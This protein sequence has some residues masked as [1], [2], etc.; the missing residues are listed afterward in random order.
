M[1]YR[2]VE[3]F[4]N[5]VPDN[6][7]LHRTYG[8]LPF[9]KETFEVKK[10]SEILEQNFDEANKRFHGKRLVVHGTI[11]N[12]GKDIHD[13][14]SFELSDE[15]GGYCYVLCC[16][17]TEAE[18]G[19]YEIGDEVIV[20][21]NY[22]TVHEQF[23]ICLKNCYV[24]GAKPTRISRLGLG[25][26]GMNMSNK[27]SSIETIHYAL[28]HGINLLNTGEFYGGGESE[29]VL[30]EALKDVPREKYFLSLKF[31]VLPQPGGGIYGLDVNPFNV[32]GHLA[33]SLHRLGL[34]YVDL[35][36]PARMDET[37]PV[38]DLME[39]MNEVVEEGY[40]RNIGL[41]QLSP[42]NLERAV[43]VAKIKTIELDY[44]LA[45]RSIE[46]NG[47]LDIARANNIDILAFGVLSHG[48]LSDNSQ[49]RMPAELKE[50][51]IRGLRE[52]ANEKNTTVEKL[53][54]AYVYAKNPD[55]SILIGTTKKEHLQDA[56]D[57]LSIELSPE[58]IVRIENAFPADKLPKGMARNF[59][60]TNGRMANAG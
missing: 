25:C 59:I 5:R 44:S 35:F 4:E 20:E 46:T 45:N 11:V 19:N 28:D 43:K 52:I 55:M 56:I 48:L 24:K 13:M 38:E 33:Y 41:T 12:K 6:D 26:M 47:I 32:K 40:V 30:R 3:V 9:E 18:Y 36:Q 57:A 23:G 16:L 31:G 17:H 49:G 15:K 27:E 54:Q 34:D 1:A 7:Y 22:L 29:M 51:L 37:V 8:I 60:F 58:D 50:E 42:E 21:G 10:L 39:A 14:P 2:H 53:C